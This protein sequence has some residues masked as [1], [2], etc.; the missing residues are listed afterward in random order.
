MEDFLILQERVKNSIY[1]G[2]SHFR[3]F[4]SALEGASGSKKPRKVNKICEDIAEA[5]VS[6]TN[7]DGGAILIG[8]EDDGTIT[9]VQHAEAEVDGMLMAAKDRIMLADKLP[10][11]YSQKL[12]IDDKLILY[13]EVDKATDRVFQLTDGRCMRRNDKS[14]FPESADQINFDRR[15]I[16]SREFDRKFRDGATV[17]DLDISNLRPIA[18]EYILCLSP[19]RYFQQ[20]GLAEYGPAGLQ[21]REAALLLFGKNI[22]DWSPGCYLRIIKV[23]GKELQSGEKYNVVFDKPFRGNIFNLIFKSWEELKS[24]IA[25][26]TEFG[27]DAMFQESY[28]YPEGA[29]REAILN[30]IAHR[31]YTNSN[32]LEIFIYSNRLEIKSPGALLSNI[33]IP[34]L[35]KLEGSH[36]SRNPLIAK[37][38]KESKFM[39]ELGE[40]IKRI[41]ELTANSDMQRP[42]LYSNGNSFTIRLFRS[43]NQ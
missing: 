43:G 42:E 22:E 28:T 32:G 29:V 9:G 1:L 6:F 23:N 31:D 26:K 16:K 8:V 10:L 13:F 36:E 2:E 38:L 24:Y 25:D 27:T 3:E 17:N 41:F 35:Y 33:T 34:D 39:R 20:I 5:L 11:R 37:V 14:T 18:N 40:G 19:E 12:I 30:A 15:E 4:K 21:L 7:A